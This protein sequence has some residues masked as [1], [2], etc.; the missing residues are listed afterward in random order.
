MTFAGLATSIALAAAAG[1][2]PVTAPAPLSARPPP[3]APGSRPG[4]PRALRLAVPEAKVLGEVPRRQVAVLEQALLAEIR[5]LEAVSAIGVSEI[6]EMLAFEYQR[7]M[8]GCQAD[9]ACLAEIA[10]ALGV[11]EMISVQLTASEA[12]LALSVKRID[13]RGTRVSGESQQ[14][15]K[16]TSGGEELLGA[17][18]PAVAALF[19]DRLLR[20][21][22]TRGVAR[23]VALRL[24]PPPLPRW[25]FAVTAGAAVAAAAAGATFGLMAN[26]STTQYND[27]LRRSTAEQVPGGQLVALQ[28]QASSRRG[29]AGV[30][31]AAGAGLAV[32][33]GVEA[34][35]TDWHGY[36]GAVTVSPAGAAVNVR[37]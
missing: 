33:A 32:A 22:L 11:D 27:L 34:F 30:L 31:L 8:L 7:Q 26:D 15:L 4:V 6:K 12:S 37:F 35:F 10:G 24:N 1:P 17:V 13:M 36:R 19:P 23:E 14:R 25:V 29:T 9:E 18:G 16:R 20:P 5:K 21:G 3:A 28:D 2:P